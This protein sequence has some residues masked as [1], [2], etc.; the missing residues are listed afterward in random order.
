MTVIRLA[1]LRGAVAALGRV[2]LRRRAGDDLA[3]RDVVASEPVSEVVEHSWSC[4][5]GQEYRV[6]GEG[7]HRVYWKAD[8]SVS[9][10]VLDGACV[11]CGKPLPGEHPR[12]TESEQRREEPAERS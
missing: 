3:P 5:C 1:A 12:E 2:V 11:E 10:P 8:A 7:R 6:S 4:E 9:D